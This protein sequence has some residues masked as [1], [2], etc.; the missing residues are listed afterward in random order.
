MTERAPQSSGLLYVHAFDPSELDDPT[1]GPGRGG[2][3]LAVRLSELAVSPTEMSQILRAPLEPGVPPSGVAHVVKLIRK[4]PANFSRNEPSRRRAASV[5]WM[6]EL[7]GARRSATA[8]GKRRAAASTFAGSTRGCGQPSSP[9]AGCP[10]F[11][12]A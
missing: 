12:F 10:T 5:K 4:F 6:V 3:S 1:G 2:K 7:A 9:E 8:V 11:R